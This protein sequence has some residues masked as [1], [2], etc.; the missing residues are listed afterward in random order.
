MTSGKENVMVS[1]DSEYA[2]PVRWPV[3]HGCGH[4]GSARSLGTLCRS[5]SHQIYRST[6][7]TLSRPGGRWV[8]VPPSHMGR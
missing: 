2:S 8:W 6:A 4:L 5:C 7:A 3:C 1:N